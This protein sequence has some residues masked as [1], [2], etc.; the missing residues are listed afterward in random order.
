[1]ATLGLFAIR[2][3]INKNSYGILNYGL[4]LITVLIICRF[5][6]TNLDFVFRGILFIAVGAGFFFT[7]YLL[8]KKQGKN[9]INSNTKSHE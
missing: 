9:A 1:V 4:L 2:I 6:D 5:F 7:N 8:L 3:G